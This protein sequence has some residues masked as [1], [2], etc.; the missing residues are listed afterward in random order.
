MDDTNLDYP[1]SSSAGPLP[2]VWEMI[3]GIFLAGSVAALCYLSQPA[4]NL[5]GQDLATLN[6]QLGNMLARHP[7]LEKPRGH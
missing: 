3:F 4:A 6:E 2:A 1:R 5:S 7:Q